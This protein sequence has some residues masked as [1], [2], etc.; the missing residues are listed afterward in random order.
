[1]IENGFSLDEQS[2]ETMITYNKVGSR[3]TPEIIAHYKQIKMKL[4]L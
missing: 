1:M 3:D 2:N 4:I